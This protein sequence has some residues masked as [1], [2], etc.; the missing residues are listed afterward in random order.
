MKSVDERRCFA[1]FF[2][3][4]VATCALYGWAAVDWDRVNVLHL[5]ECTGTLVILY[6]C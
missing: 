1:S 6:D 5:R 4:I 2:T 3:M